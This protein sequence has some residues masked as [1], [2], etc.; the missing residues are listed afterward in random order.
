MREAEAKAKAA[1]QTAKPGVEPW[2]F[3]VDYRLDT[4][5]PS[6]KGDHATRYNA[7]IALIKELGP[8]PWHVATSMWEIHSHQTRDTVLAAL[9][10]PLDVKIDVV[11]VTPIGV[12][13][14][15]GDPKK[16]KG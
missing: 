2:R 11:A 8:T 10:Q 5:S 1:R 7:L 3:A 9:T 13:K 4:K 15:F 16:L 14:T 12:T 6:P